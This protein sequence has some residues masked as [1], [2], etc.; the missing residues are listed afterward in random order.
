MSVTKMTFQQVR[1]HV[2]SVVKR[3]VIVLVMSPVVACSSPPSPIP[4]G[5]DTHWYGNITTGKKF[6][7]HIGD[8]YSS[9][10][11]ALI[12]QGYQ[13]S[14]FYSEEFVS[15]DGR[16]GV[17]FECAPNRKFAKF[18]MKRIGRSG[19]IFVVVENEKV[20]QLVWS[21]SVIQIP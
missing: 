6:E 2:A 19:S 4:E 18:R 3:L 20:A 15:C 12:N 10:K 7:V 17:T 5:T 1:S 14:K 9:A 11:T 8:Q 13:L 21:F 16:N